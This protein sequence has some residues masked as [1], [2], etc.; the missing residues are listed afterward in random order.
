M[1]T[2]KFL[3]AGALLFFVTQTLQAQEVLALN[4][5]EETIVMIKMTESIPTYDGGNE[6]LRE[7][8]KMNL[9]YPKT[10]KRMGK[11]GVVLVEFYI[12]EEGEIHNPKV[13][14]ANFTSLEKEAIRLVKKMPNWIPASQ[15]G[16]PVGVNFQLP[17][18]F[19]L[20]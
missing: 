5:S 8:L 4:D 7:F 3:S 9:V 10:A 18:H 20:R 12:D 17:I 19:K 2:F 6:S 14:N 11:E 13:K 16:I 15:N 1:K